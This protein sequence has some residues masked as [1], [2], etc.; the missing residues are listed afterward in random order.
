MKVDPNTNRLLTVVGFTCWPILGP[1]L[2]PTSPTRK[3]TAS[4]CAGVIGGIAS[5]LVAA[6]IT[7][8]AFTSPTQFARK[9]LLSRLITTSRLLNIM[10]RAEALITQSVC[11]IVCCAI[12]P[13]LDEGDY[14]PKLPITDRGARLERAATV[15]CQQSLGNA[16]EILCR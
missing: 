1:R 12:E 13:L 6:P 11:W 2:R 7:K 4:Y 16:Q 3:T 5:A 10:A 14:T 15:T 8:L 9:R